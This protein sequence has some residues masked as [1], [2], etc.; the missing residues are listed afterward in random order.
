MASIRE[1]I[2]VWLR[3]ANSS[4]RGDILILALIVMVLVSLLIGPLLSHMS[5]GMKNSKEVYTARTAEQ[6]AADAG[7]TR[8]MWYIKYQSEDVPESFSINNINN[9]TVFVNISKV[10]NEDESDTYSISSRAGSTTIDAQI[11]TTAAIPEVPPTPPE[12][13]VGL[14]ANGISAL[15]GDITFNAGNASITG[16]AFVTG[17]KV[18]F[19]TSGCLCLRRNKRKRDCKRR[20]DHSKSRKHGRPSGQ[21]SQRHT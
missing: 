7:V 13:S 18:A 16:D 10:T 14:F 12:D 17:G 3:K 19:P 9:K 4:E 1:K 2:A 6:Y 8:A 21:S 11:N 15:N 5:T 20:P